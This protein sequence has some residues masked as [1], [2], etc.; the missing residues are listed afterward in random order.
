MSIRKFLGFDRR[1]AAASAETETVRKIAAELDRLEPERARFV[2]AFGYLLSRVARAD[3]VITPDETS[4]MERIIM[5]HGGLPEEQAILIVQMS[6][7]QS[8]LFGGTENYLVTREFNRIATHEQKL[9]LLDCLFAVCSADR[10]ITTVE[11]NEI[12]QIA[13]EMRIEHRDFI[14]ARARYRDHLA[15]LKN[16]PERP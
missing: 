4:A 9:A 2:A 16:P 7:T 12:A 10:H 8:T 15:V 3:M 5:E 11:D 1:N 14:A 13:D 6:K